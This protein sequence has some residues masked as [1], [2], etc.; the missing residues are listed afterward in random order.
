MLY[1][2]NYR[3]QRDYH[4][5]RQ[6]LILY[7]LVSSQATRQQDKE[8]RDIKREVHSV[9]EETGELIPSIASKNNQLGENYVPPPPP[10]PPLDTDR[11]RSA[12]NSD[13][14]TRS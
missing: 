11:L 14:K 13:G 1:S 9:M 12:T 10:P 6:L 8:D 7:S 3:Y 2:Q 5:S 4:T